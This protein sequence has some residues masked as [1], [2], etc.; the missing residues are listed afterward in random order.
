MR[1]AMIAHA[2]FTY[3]EEAC[4]LVA[5]DE[6]G[7]LRM[8]YC[9]TNRDRSRYRFTVDPTEHFRALRHAE[10]RG[11]NLAGS[12]HSHPNSPAIPSQ[13]DIEGALDPE[14][15]YFVVSLV[16]SDRPDVRAFEMRNGTA[17]ER[18]VETG[19]S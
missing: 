5:A 19:P 9:L 8:V 12:F 10:S 1:E 13:R 18:S 6:T 2:R 16:D 14:W 7:R 3:P 11:W 17:T 4:G 15:V